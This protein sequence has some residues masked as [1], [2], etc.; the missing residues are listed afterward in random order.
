MKRITFDAIPKWAIYPLEYGVNNDP[1]LSKESKKLINDFIHK[2]FPNGYS[3]YIKWD[4]ERFSY[5]PDIG[6]VEYVEVIEVDF[7]VN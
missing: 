5:F 4:T 2:Y 3:M 7:Y 1:L 6:V